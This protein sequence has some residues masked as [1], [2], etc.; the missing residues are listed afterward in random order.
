[1]GVSTALGM[2]VWMWTPILR[3]LVHTTWASN[4]SV[5]WASILSAHG[6]PAGST[7][8]G[9]HMYATWATKTAALWAPT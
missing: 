6:H 9:V 7:I 3:V 1:M 5:R 4:M 2:D 8:M